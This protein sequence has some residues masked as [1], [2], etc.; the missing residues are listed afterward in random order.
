[1]RHIYLVRGGAQRLHA[2]CRLSVFEDG[3]GWDFAGRGRV[4]ARYHQPARYDE[5]VV[6]L[7]CLDAL[8]TP[9]MA[10]TYEVRRAGDGC[11]LV[12]GK[13]THVSVD[14]DGRVRRLPEEL[15]LLFR[16]ALPPG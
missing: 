13:S 1:M 14:P 10:F 11:L 12:T 5:E 16:T 15:R 8:G 2:L 4:T 9:G 7:A 6:V 3:G